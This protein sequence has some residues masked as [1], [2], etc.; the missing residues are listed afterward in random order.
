MTTTVVRLPP[1]TTSEPG[2]STHSSPHL[3]AQTAVSLDDDVMC[4]DSF[5]VVCD[6]LIQAPRE[7][8]RGKTIKKK[9]AAAGTIR[10][11]NPDGTFTTRTASGK[12]VTRPPLKRNPTSNS[13]LAVAA[14][15][16]AVAKLQPLTRS[17]TAESVP[18]ASEGS[19]DSQTPSPQ[20]ASPDALPDTFRSGIYCSKECQAK[21]AARSAETYHSLARN[22]SYDFSSG[23]PPHPL[24]PIERINTSLSGNMYAPP[25]P[26]LMSDGDT[27][28]TSTKS[29]DAR[30]STDSNPPIIQDGPVSSAPK[31]MEYFQLYREQPDE[32]WHENQRQRRLSMQPSAMRP[33]SMLRQ[34]SQQ[35]QYSQASYSNGPSTGGISTDSLSSMWGD[36]LGRSV[37]GHGRPR[38]S[39][40][41]ARTSVSS[42]DR[43]PNAAA[44]L[45]VSSAR[46]HFRTNPSQTSLNLPSPGNVE[47]WSAEFGSQPKH[48][49]SLYQSYLASFGQRDI[50]SPK[51]IPQYSSSI[52]VSVDLRRPSFG[53][54]T[55][56]GR[57]ASGTIRGRRPETFGQDKPVTWDSFAKQE[58][59]AIN[60][61]TALTR[62]GAVPIP[63]SLP[64]TKEVELDSTPKQS[65]EMKGGQWVIRYHVPTPG[66]PGLAKGAADRSSASVHSNSSS[67][68]GGSSRLHMQPRANSL[69]VPRQAALSSSQ[70]TA[71]ASRTPQNSMPPPSFVP[72]GAGRRASAQPSSEMGA[73][74]LGQATL[75]TVSVTAE[76]ALG[77]SVPNGTAKGFSWEKLEK[78][79]KVKVM[80]LPQG[81]KVERKG[82]FY[83]E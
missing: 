23:Y 45:P 25:S 43:S 28:S 63:C 79:G 51:P 47:V 48:T 6:R 24:S 17:K 27:A 3:P 9:P 75:S 19:P 26:L 57:R 56:S 49:L 32:A 73:L 59:D 72:A 82:L 68:S 69:A 55:S 30:T 11:R 65:Y 8:Q 77:A 81:L 64:K 4:F 80:E 74:R 67:E 40:R 83:F 13:R 39:S 20:P 12:T 53:T 22:M 1:T 14:A 78:Q 60:Q 10:V 38:A 42:S 46:P 62:V 58:S 44:P 71:G 36:A 66:A 34:Q 7:P 2:P 18:A 15:T 5:C 70:S 54:T 31:I 21:E 29:G 61:R 33:M 37:S 35:S 76:H 50:S 52:G 41:H 16:N